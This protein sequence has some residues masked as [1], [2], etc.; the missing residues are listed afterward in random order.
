MIKNSKLL[1]V[2][3][4]VSLLA[5]TACGGGG[6]SDDPAGSGVSV[7]QPVKMKVDGGLVNVKDNKEGT[8]KYEQSDKSDILVV[9]GLRLNIPTGLVEDRH[10]LAENSDHRVNAAYA[11]YSYSGISFNPDY[12][13]SNGKKNDIYIYYQGELTPESS[14]PKTG[15]IT[16]QGGAAFDKT[17]WNMAGAF[18]IDTDEVGNNINASHRATYAASVELTADFDQKKLT[19]RVFEL[20]T[21]V[22]RVVITE[23]NSGK[24]FNE[25]PINADI[26]GNTFAGTKN[27]VTT[28]GKF[29]GPNAES[30]AGT[31]NDKNQKI[32]GSFTA[33]KTNK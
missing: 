12:K 30:I 29:F 23:T 11:E 7:N 18:L 21:P 26:K 13:D 20:A 4:A 15:R 17:N 3:T 14:M 33:D 8:A 27:N 16:Y 9:N 1:A 2:S 6:G 5:L 10:F 24:K 28:E 19:G 22:N 25:I 31:F 32:Q